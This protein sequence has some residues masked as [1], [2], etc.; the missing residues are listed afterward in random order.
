MTE[1]LTIA[2]RRLALRRRFPVWQP[3]SLARWLDRCAA[4]YPQR[5]FVLSDATAQTYR[6]VA[7][8]SRHLAAGLAA[9]GVRSGDRVGMV[10]ANH[11]QFVAV[12]FAIARVGAVAVPFNYLYRQD[13][14]AF[15]L[16]DSRCRILITMSEFGS[17]D[18]Q[19][20]LDGIVPGWDAPGFHRRARTAD[21]VPDLRGVVVVPTGAAPRRGALSL[22]EL[23]DMGR[24]R[25]P[26]FEAPAV[27]PASAG[28]MLYTS[29]TTGSPKGVVVSHDAVLRTAYASALTRAF[30]DGRRI[31]SSLP[32]YHMF[33]YVEGLLAVMYV[34][35]AIIMQPSFSPEGYFGG[36]EKHRA[37][38]ILCVPTMAVALVQSPARFDYQLSSLRAILC[39]S[40]PAPVWLWQQVVSDFAVTEIVTGYGMTECGGAMTLTLPEDPLEN[41]TTTVGRPKMAGA[42]GITDTDALVRYRTVDP[43]TFTDTAGEGELV[44][45][46][47][48]VM[49][50]YW[51]RPFDTERTLRD[52]W[53]RSG[54]LGRI[55][56]DGYLQVTGRSKELYKSGG[57]L[58][59]PKEIEDLLARHPGISQVFA[60]GLTD[61]RWGEIG[62]VVVVPAPG[63][64]VTE[65]DILQVCRE[66][67]ARF[68]V[69]KRVVFYR[70]EDLPTTPTGKVQ[71]YRLVQQITGSREPAHGT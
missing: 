61:E 5:P 23:T 25:L 53:L 19:D 70:A 27:D 7:E 6:D 11:P 9:L 22:R 28:D 64:G 3:I 33:G 36:I 48:T 39:G 8:Q 49:T 47:P 46:G 20:M 66:K 63:H 14:L 30:E 17:L 38:D 54:D 67:L 44:S 43:D 2:D 52:G 55:R 42:A 1:P 40:A 31:L 58:V 68:K 16:A 59:M 60:I 4:D 15:V 65:S 56:P 13:E 32:C 35:G 34:G 69:P 21:E 12:K 37:T 50:G 51:N 57:E 18:Y 10:L 24:A 29:G 62:C 26:L 41:L 45:T 71:K